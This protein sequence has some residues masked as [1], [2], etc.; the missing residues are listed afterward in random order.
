[1]IHAAW[2]HR[3]IFRRQKILY[4]VYYALILLIR[5]GC[6]LPG[7]NSLKYP[8]PKTKVMLTYKPKKMY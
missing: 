1:M 5:L 7:L 2:K 3:N 4:K 6:M 8:S